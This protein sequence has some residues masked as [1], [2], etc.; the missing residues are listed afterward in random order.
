MVLAWQNFFL[1][2]SYRLSE[3]YGRYLIDSGRWTIDEKLPEVPSALYLLGFPEHFLIIGN[4]RHFGR[5][6]EI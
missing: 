2:Q 6:T 3:Y 1:D 4:R 5:L